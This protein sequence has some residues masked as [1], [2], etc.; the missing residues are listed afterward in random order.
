MKE[1]QVARGQLL[2]AREDTAILLEL[3]DATFDQVALFV[4]RVVAVAWVDAALLGRNGG[5]RMQLFLDV[6]DGGVGIVASIGQHFLGLLPG[7]QRDGLRVVARRAAGED[8]LQRVA[9]R[10]HQ[11][12]DLRAEAAARAIEQ[13]DIEKP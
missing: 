2:K 7:Q 3:V 12:V 6:G 5:G 10:I 4:R 11:H 9:Q 1:G 8:K 13:N